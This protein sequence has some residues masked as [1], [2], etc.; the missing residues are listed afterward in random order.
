M[1]AYAPGPMEGDKEGCRATVLKYSVVTVTAFIFTI[2]L[3]LAGHIATIAR[4]R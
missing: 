3:V 1:A 4:M 2:F